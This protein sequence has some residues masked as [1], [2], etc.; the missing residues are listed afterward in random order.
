M[1]F[2]ILLIVAL[3]LGGCATKEPIHDVIGAAIEPPPGRIL[4]VRVVATAIQRAGQ[5][6]GW[7]MTVEGPGLLA[8]RLARRS[9]LAV[10]VIEYNAGSYSIR[11]RESVNLDARDGQI[12][13]GYNE[14]VKSLDKAIR[15][16]LQT[17]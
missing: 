4:S 5:S 10:V 11:Y 1:R 17:L 8:G 14:W 7:Q 3:S 15:N 12:H 6:L 13:R 2:S 16:E 9:H